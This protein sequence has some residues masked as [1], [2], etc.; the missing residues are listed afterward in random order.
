MEIEDSSSCD[1][2]SLMQIIQGLQDVQAG[3]IKNHLFSINESF[4]EIDCDNL[5]YMSN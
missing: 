2:E 3:I 4:E 1:D 5:R